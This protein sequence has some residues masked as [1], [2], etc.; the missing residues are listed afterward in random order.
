MNCTASWLRE[1]D[2]DQPWPNGNWVHCPHPSTDTRII[3]LTDEVVIALGFCP[4]HIE[5]FDSV[6]D[7]D[8]SYFRMIG[9]TTV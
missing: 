6:N 2:P 7:E 5:L 8:G 1:L 4:A 9:G 3:R